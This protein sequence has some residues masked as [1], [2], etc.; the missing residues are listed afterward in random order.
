MKKTIK[1]TRVWSVLVALAAVLAMAVA[2]APA[3]ANVNGQFCQ[4]L[5]LS[6]GATCHSPYYHTFFDEVEGYSDNN[7]PTCVGISTAP[8]GGSNLVNACSSGAMDCL[9]AC[10]HFYSGYAYVHNHGQVGDYYTGVLDAAS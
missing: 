9:S 2:A 5:W 10:T 4:H 3:S 8:S 7:R 6:S 1:A